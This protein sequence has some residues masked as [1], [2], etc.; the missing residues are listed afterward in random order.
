M[1]TLNSK[2]ADSAQLLLEQTT[3]R[4]SLADEQQCIAII[5]AYVDKSDIG[6]TH[7]VELEKSITRME[8]IYK[9]VRGS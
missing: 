5:T 9:R 6:V 8:K 3:I 2:H 1:P 7:M 4:L